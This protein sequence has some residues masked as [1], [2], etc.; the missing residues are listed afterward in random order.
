[1]TAKTLDLL[2]LGEPLMEFSQ[3]EGSNYLRG[4]GGDT[5]NCAIAAARHGAKSGYIS[6]VGADEFGE[7]FLELWR[8][9]G[10]D[11]TAVK[12]TPTAHT[13][14]YFVS[15]GPSGHQFSYLRSQSAASTLDIADVEAAGI[16][17]SQ[18][19]HLS[20]ISQAI[21]DSACDAGFRSIEIARE[22]GT[23]V[24][25]DTNLRLKLWTLDR[26][27]AV[28]HSAAAMAHV[29]LPSIE[30]ATQLCGRT[31]PDAVLDFYL[32]LGVEIV[33][34]TLGDRG[35]MIA[36]PERREL[37]PAR[38]VEVVDATGAGDAF[39]G[40]FLARLAAGDDPFTAGQYANAAASL[41]TCSHGAVT[42]LPHADDVRRVLVADAMCS[43]S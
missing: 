25:Y 41:A 43:D 1:M 30:D 10:V 12:Q 14:V 20:G 39:D 36:T 9:E 2:C 16:E 32:E 40:A 27:R 4:F 29:L 13:G 8:T 19:L 34:L 21:S 33:A 3:V 22:S 24:A 42:P 6:R 28:I 18:W 15:H 11:T 31:E 23:R 5:S 7:S 17:W 26:A 37:I 38:S 35:A